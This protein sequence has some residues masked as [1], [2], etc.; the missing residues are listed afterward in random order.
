MRVEAGHNL[1]RD[2]YDFIVRSIQSEGMPPTIREIG[3]AVGI[4]STSHINHHL[5][6]TLYIL[7]KGKGKG[8]ALR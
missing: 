8:S 5:S 3:L 1:Q 2:I 4:T 6:L 7:T